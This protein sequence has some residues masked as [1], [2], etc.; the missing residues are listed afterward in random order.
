MHR[1]QAALAGAF[2]L[3]VSG[4]GGGGGSEPRATPSPSARLVFSAIADDGGRAPSGV[5]HTR[6][7]ELRN[8]GD[9]AAR[10]LVVTV[11]PDAQALVLPLTCESSDCTPR[12]DGGVEIPELPAGAAVVLSQRLRI[13]PGYRGAARNDWSA[14]GSGTLA[15][16]SQDLRAYVTDLAVTVGEP[17]A[18]LVH[19]VTLSNLGP[20]DAS[21][22]TW[23][24]LPAPGQALR[25]TGC[26]ATGGAVCPATLADAMTL[27]RLA[28][29]GVL[30]LRVQAPAGGVATRVEAAG[31]ADPG[32]DG[33]SRGQERVAHLA[34]TDL[35]GRAYR[36]SN[37]VAGSLRVTAAG[38]DYRSAYAVHVSGQGLL[39][40]AGSP[41]PPWSRGALHLFEPVLIL[42]LDIGG[43]RKP[44]LAPRDLVTRLAELE[45]VS[46]NVLGS[47]ADPSGKPTDAYVGSARFQDGVLQLCLPDAPTPFAQCP[48]GRL[49]RFEAAVVGT[50]IELVARDRVMRLRAA[51]SRHGPILI[52]SMRDATTGASHFWIGLPDD[53]TYPLGGGST[54]GLQESTFES[55]SG[56][57]T[58]ML[59]TLTYTNDL[60]PTVTTTPRNSPYAV[61]HVMRGGTLG[62]CKLTAQF[63]G[64]TQ[65]R[66]YLG[67][68]RGD[69]VTGIDAQDQ[70]IQDRPCFA[71]AVHHAQTMSFAAFVGTR[72]GGLMGRWMFIGATP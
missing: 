2:V 71:G 57:S 42:G 33:A 70:F 39:G 19:E 25:L 50:E 37:D 27:P 68:L 26:T 21:D 1:I 24:Q 20:D 11:S 30:K 56:Q 8:N 69:W 43:V 12:S 16:W 13:K 17:D 47:R 51:R 49:T 55:A 46:F 54:A 9:L 61:D 7:V 58:A 60:T 34:M 52:S 36:L 6:R 18:D 35:E 3:L 63:S 15:V 44:Y 10:S 64:T 66:L 48:A 53:S 28:A 38:L 29:G 72:D 67:Q 65:P 14:T 5:V 32:N 40:A 23:T 59:A 45:G 62:L 4:C 41:N 31:D 22:V